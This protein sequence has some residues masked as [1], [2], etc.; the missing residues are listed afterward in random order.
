MIIVVVM[1]AMANML[2]TIVVVIMIAM[3]N[4][5]VTIV[6]ITVVIFKMRVPSPRWPWQ[7]SWNQTR[8]GLDES[9]I[10]EHHRAPEVA[11]GRSIFLTTR[12]SLMPCIF[13]QSEE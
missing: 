12:M 5:L 4:M 11:H 9:S 7:P 13:I 6:V 2:V 3:P 8:S 10:A 1:I